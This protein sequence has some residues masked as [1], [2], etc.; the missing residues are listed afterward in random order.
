MIIADDSFVRK[1]PR[2]L[3]LEQRLEIDALVTAA[4]TASLAYDKLSTLLGQLAA[5]SSGTQPSRKMA[6]EIAMYCWSFIDSIHTF[7]SFARRRPSKSGGLMES[8]L[9]ASEGATRLRNAMDHRAGNLRNSARTKAQVYPIYGTISFYWQL[10]NPRKWTVH[11]LTLGT[12]HHAEHR[13]PPIVGGVLPHGPG[14]SNVIL[15]AFGEDLS[16]S[17][18]VSLLGP[19]VAAFEEMLLS[20]IPPGIRKA[21]EEAGEDVDKIM[22][23]YAGLMKLTYGMEAPFWWELPG[24][25]ARIHVK[26]WRGRR[27]TKRLLAHGRRPIG[28]LKSRRS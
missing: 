2:A 9:T 26:R 12:M 22:G 25:S 6:A 10:Q 17:N 3:A 21:A 18:L 23:E 11:Q 24:N 4:D 8:F 1:I 27:W 13:F 19:A 20:V 14:A 5:L 16:L 28:H 7:R 15:G